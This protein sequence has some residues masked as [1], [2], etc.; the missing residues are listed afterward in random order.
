MRPRAPGPIGCAQ[1]GDL[2]LDVR[3]KPT[4]VVLREMFNNMKDKSV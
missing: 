2:S 1:P 4:R 3:D